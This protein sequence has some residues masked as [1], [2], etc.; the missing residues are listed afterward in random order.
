M[1][2]LL[3]L[4]AAAGALWLRHAETRLI[5]FP[6]RGIETTPRQLGLD[7]QEIWLNTRDGVKINGWF[8]PSRHPNGF[9]LLL[10]HGNAGNISHRLEKYAVLLD[11]G[12]DVLA[13]DYRGYG[14]SGGQPD[15]AGT[16]LDADA[17]YRYLAE[18]RN[19]APQRIVLYGESLGTAVA[20]DLASR[21]ENGG[22]ILE[23]GFTSVPDA[24]R[25]MY[26]W[27]PLRWLLRT[28][29]RSLDKIGRI[30]APL[31]IFHS[32][33]DEFF[34]LRHAQRL[35]AAATPPKRLVELDGGHNDAFLV[36][37]TL[38]RSALQRFFGELRAAAAVPHGQ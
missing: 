20:V 16:Y 23:E 13:I 28:Q 22:V 2:I 6:E 15:E 19:I 35:L 26:P 38:Y 33:D 9:T 34:S 11:L 3:L 30:H 7:Y 14:K 4:A 17:A 10:L 21:V 32:R 12:A 8:M 36:S 27:L 29:Y 18:Q 5:Y 31:L 24:A 25:E 1:L 37:K